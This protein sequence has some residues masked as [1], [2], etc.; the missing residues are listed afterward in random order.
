MNDKQSHTP[1]PWN[2]NVSGIC[3][4][5]F[6]IRGNGVAAPPDGDPTEQWKT[7][8]AHIVRCVNAYPKLVAA[9]RDAEKSLGAVSGLLHSYPRPSNDPNGRTLLNAEE[10]AKAACFVARAVLA[11]VESN[12]E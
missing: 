12:E 4:D 2:F 8:A 6:A 11:E 10:H 7:D 9:L 5:I 3:D 1:T